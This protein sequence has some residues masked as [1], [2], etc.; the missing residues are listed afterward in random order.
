MKPS[1]SR[2]STRYENKQHGSSEFPYAAYRSLIPDLMHSYPLH[3]HNEMEISYIL[4]GSCIISVNGTPVRALANDLILILPNQLHSIEQDEAQ[5]AEYYTFVFD[6]RLL[7][8][9]SPADACFC[10]YIKPY[11]EGR[12]LLPL[13]IDPSCTG[14]SQIRECFTDLLE[15][16][17]DGSSI[18]GRELFIK[19]R[20]FAI[21]SLLE[22]LKE[23]AVSDVSASLQLV[24]IQ[25]MKSLLR[26][27]SENYR[28]PLT[29]QEAASF[30]GYST[31]YFM[32][33][34]KAFT[35]S[36]FI[37]YLNRYRVKKAGELLCST[38]LTILEI[39]E[40]VGFENLSYF[41]RIFKRQYGVT[42]RKYRLE[43]NAPLSLSAE[44]GPVSQWHPI[45]RPPES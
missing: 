37:G 16:E 41:I 4:K 25:K 23:P 12:S 17:N 2:P 35:S 34:F 29:L 11:L 30:C 1:S 39:S 9:D 42:P 8:Q 31:S 40:N 22:T 18:P 15:A 13:K 28:K 26:F 24:R 7:G 44:G 36:T 43:H 20:L 32:K 21:F 6:L 33:F 5:T 14:Y 27:I 10:K 45:S 38:S 19:S 3:W